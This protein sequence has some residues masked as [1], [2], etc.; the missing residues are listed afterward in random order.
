[1]FEL[2]FP[3]GIQK[4]NSQEEATQMLEQHFGYMLPDLTQLLDRI[5]MDFNGEKQ[6]LMPSLMVI[7]KEDYEKLQLNLSEK[8]T[9]LKVSA[10]SSDK[11]EIDFDSLINETGEER[12]GGKIFFPDPFGSFTV[13]ERSDATYYIQAFISIEMSSYNDKL[14]SVKVTGDGVEL[15]SFL[16]CEIIPLKDFVKFNNFIQ[17]KMNAFAV[18][19]RH[20]QSH[21]FKRCP[22]CQ[23]PF[24]DPVLFCDK[25]GFTNKLNKGVDNI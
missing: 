8:V 24:K 17:I 3:D 18:L 16:S 6:K 22:E 1:L 21:A 11:E 4:A 7:P 5:Q 14:K 23:T 25:C 9:D 12:K 20:Y 15:N 10:N 13:E 2:H 19:Q